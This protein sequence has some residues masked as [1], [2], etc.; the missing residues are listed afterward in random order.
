MSWCFWQQAD[1]W[2]IETWPNCGP[3]VN[4]KL[5]F[6]RNIH[7]FIEKAFVATRKLCLRLQRMQ[8]HCPK[9]PPRYSKSWKSSEIQIQL[10]PKCRLMPPSCSFCIKSQEN[11]NQRDQRQSSQLI[12]NRSLV[13]VIGLPCRSIL[14]Q[15]NLRYGL[16]GN[17]RHLVS[18]RPYA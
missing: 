2:E 17:S 18:N 15:K 11:I 10:N 6:V 12:P 9:E 1:N 13:G 4:T 5:R 14:S 16:A 7:N 3:I 8:S